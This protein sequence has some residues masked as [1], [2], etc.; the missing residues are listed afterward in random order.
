MEAHLHLPKKVI[1]TDDTITQAINQL[2]TWKIRK[3]LF[4]YSKSACNESMLMQFLNLAAEKKIKLLFYA[5]PKGEPTIEMLNSAIAY[6]HKEH[7]EAL[8][9]LGGGSAIDLAKATAA[10][11]K[12]GA[13]KLKELATYEKIN[14]YPFIAIPTTAGTG[15]EATKVTVITDE[16]SG[17]KFNPG[18]PDLI[19]DVAILDASWS[20]YVPKKITAQ[21]GLDALTHAVEAYVSTN[22][23]MLSDFYAE[24]AMELIHQ[25][26]PLAY[27]DGTNMEA[28]Q[29]MLLGS[30]YAG[31]A[32]SN[33]ST[34][35]A[36]ATGR[37]LGVRWHMPHGL[38]VALM[39]PFVA[40]FSY[41]SCQQKY[42]RIA[43]IFGLK[44]GK[45][46]ASYLKNLNDAFHI[47]EEAEHLI[48]EEFEQSLEE[49]T[50]N[51]LKGNGIATNYRIPNEQN[52]HDLFMEMITEVK[53][54]SIS[55]I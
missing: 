16:Q 48:N 27:E 46:L 31:V 3:A 55:K 47:W 18:H 25:S 8:V 5:M 38:S 13:Y 29:K 23:T 37:A 9:A 10:L 14:R 6:T 15:S 4:I 21:T 49:M 54:K 11:A 35:L 20:M 1:V 12:D 17:V 39:H 50:A 22:S 19:P 34:N 45:E 30:F 33:A 28:R 52:I 42:D 44:S 2:S 24:K 51:A 32:F 40:A 26:L 7:A 43:S 53:H 36:H 41:E